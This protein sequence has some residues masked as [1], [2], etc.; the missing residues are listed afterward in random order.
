MWS[1]PVD[2]HVLFD[3]GCSGTS[4]ECFN[5]WNGEFKMSRMVESLGISAGTVVGV[6]CI[7]RTNVVGFSVIVPSDNLE[8][9][10]FILELENLFPSVVP[11]SL[12][13]EEPVLGVR[14]FFTKVSEDWLLI[15]FL[16]YLRSR[17]YTK[18]RRAP[19]N[20]SERDR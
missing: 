13:V 5:V 6:R 3:D 16:G 8:E 15:W 19:C 2:Q 12:G 9:L 10:E 17:T 7:V 11:Q 14:H 18:E 1:V 20:P 4:L